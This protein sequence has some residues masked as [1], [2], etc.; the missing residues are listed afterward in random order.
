MIF[1]VSKLFAADFSEKE[2]L[3]KNDDAKIT[4]AGTLTAPSD[5][6]PRA[7]LVLATGSGQQNRDEEVMGH[8][9]FKVIA[10]YLSARGYAVLRMDD[11]GIGGSEGDFAAST[12]D[13]YL[14]DIR[15]GVDYLRSQYPSVK[16]GVLGHSEGGGVAII[17]GSGETPIADFIITLAAPAWAGDSIVMSQARALAVAM[18]GRWDNEALQRQ[19]LDVAKSPMNKAIAQSCIYSLLASNVGEAANIP[20]VKEQLLAQSNALLSPNY[21]R[22]LRYNPEADIRAVAVPWLALNGDKDCQVLVENLA[23]I[24][25]LNPKAETRIMTQHNHLFQHCTTGL[26]NEYQTISEDIS[27]ET[28]S[29]IAAWLDEL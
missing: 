16:A 22:L 12:A 10:E 9:P 5:R 28:L 11:R 13:D 24:K 6:T 21:R 20:A 25:D 17:A 2:V 18:T 14:G 26:I 15:S 23:T 27:E 8:K 7:I 29:A 1:A 3:V 4:L 19:L